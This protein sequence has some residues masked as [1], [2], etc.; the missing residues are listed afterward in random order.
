M[1]Q[2]ISQGYVSGRPTLGITGETL[3][4]FYQHYYR[5]PAGLYITEIASSSD[6]DAKGVQEGAILISIG[7]SRITSM[8]ALNS[9]IYG[10]EVGD[11][12]ETVI[13]RNGQQYRVTLTLT[14]D[15]G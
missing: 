2:L 7:D 1:A 12:V 11:T 3:S 5:L 4:N 9:A 13:Y 10:C 8:D 6:A 15:K 14:E